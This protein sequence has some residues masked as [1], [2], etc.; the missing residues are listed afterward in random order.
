MKKHVP[1]IITF[2]VISLPLLAQ[3][4]YDDY[5]DDYGDEEWMSLGQ[6]GLT[7]VSGLVFAGVGYLLSKIKPISVLGKVIMWIGLISGGG[8]VVLYILQIIGMLLSAAFSLA[9]KLL[10]IG[11]ICY[12]VYL[13]VSGIVGWL[14]KNS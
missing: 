14:R 3:H 4:N 1:L 9:W 12:I 2:L 11:V 10:I 5:S 6:V 8:S 13:F 7:L